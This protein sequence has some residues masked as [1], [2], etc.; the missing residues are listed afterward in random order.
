MTPQKWNDEAMDM[1]IDTI[2]KLLADV[3]FFHLLDD[4]GR[5][6]LA[7][8]VAVRRLGPGATIFGLGD[9]G[10]ELFIVAEGTV[11]IHTRD[12]LGQ[13][14]S[15]GKMG[16][17]EMFGELSLIDEGPRTATATTESDCVLLVLGREHLLDFMR[18]NPEASLDFMAILGERIRETHGRLRRLA[19]RNANE[20]IETRE[21]RI[22]RITDKVAGWAGSLKFFFLHVTIFAIWIGVNYVPAYTFD[23]YPFGLLTMAVSLEAILLSVMVLLTQNRQ[24]AR[25]RIRSDVE[26]EVNVKAGLQVVE[27]HSKFDALNAELV[28]RLGRLEKAVDRNL[29]PP[30][31]AS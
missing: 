14:I 7:E 12:D 8:R 5:H 1:Q 15:L 17:G 21:S 31:R 3:R 23:P 22:E 18:S 11:E 6:Q 2:E 29:P 19:A 16:P 25:D 28:R 27:L 13:K 24:S 20:A 4:S 10:E 9:A 30:P 26:Y